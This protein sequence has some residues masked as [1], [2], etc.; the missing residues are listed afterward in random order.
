MPLKDSTNG[1]I[2]SRTEESSFVMRDENILVFA[3]F[4][5]LLIVGVSVT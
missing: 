3:I 1:K 4:M 2:K 5:V